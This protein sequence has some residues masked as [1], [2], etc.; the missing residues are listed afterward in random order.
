MLVLEKFDQYLKMK[1]LRQSEARKKIVAEIFKIHEHFHIQEL[2]IKVKKYEFISR[3]TVFRT[4]Q[5]LIEA[6]FIRKI[7]DI[8]GHVHYEHIYG[9]KHH[10]HLV[11]VRCGR[12]IEVTCKLLEAEQEILCKQKDFVPV[13]HN[14]QIW[15]YCK[16]CRKKEK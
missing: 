6:G 13:N 4:V 11:C 3:A 9:H 2:L 15:G 8:H 10:D 1:K 12:E 14:L 16:D 7:T 5:L